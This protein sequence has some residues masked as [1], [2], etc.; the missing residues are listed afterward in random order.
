MFRVEENYFITE[1]RKE[2]KLREDA[3]S[4]KHDFDF[5]DDQNSNQTKRRR[6]KKIKEINDNV[7]IETTTTRNRL[8]TAALFDTDHEVQFHFRFIFLI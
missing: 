3:K 6:G 8:F 7:R 1:Y 5:L 2:L 4:I